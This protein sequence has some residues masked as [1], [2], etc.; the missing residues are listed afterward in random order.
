[1]SLRSEVPPIPFL[2]SYG[3]PPFPTPDQTATKGGTRWLNPAPGHFVPTP[4]AIGT[5]CW[6]WPAFSRQGP[7]VTLESIAR[8]AGVGIGLY[9]PNVPVRIGGKAGIRAGV[10]YVLIPMPSEEIEGLRFFGFFPPG[11][12]PLPIRPSPLP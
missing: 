11:S 9:V 12:M 10:E 7:D 2:E 6:L 4:S 5:G 8:D 1:M 3:V